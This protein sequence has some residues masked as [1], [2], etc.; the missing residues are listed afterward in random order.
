MVTK[1][2]YSCFNNPVSSDS[3]LLTF[4][5]VSVTDSSLSLP[6]SAQ[7]NMN[8]ELSSRF[9]EQMRGYIKGYKELVLRSSN[10]ESNADFVNSVRTKFLDSVEVSEHYKAGLDSLINTFFPKIAN[11]VDKTVVSPV[12]KTVDDVDK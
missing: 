6:L 1:D 9:S 5:D 4:D 11:F 12:D 7:L 2:L 8:N 10:L 3:D